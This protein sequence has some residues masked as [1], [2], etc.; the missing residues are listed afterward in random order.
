MLL[1]LRFG[2]AGEVAQPWQVEHLDKAGDRRVVAV[3]VVQPGGQAAGLVFLPGGQVQADGQHRFV[4]VHVVGVAALRLAQH[5]ACPQQLAAAGQQRRQRHAGRG[6]RVVRRVV[7][8][9]LQLELCQIGLARGYQGLGAIESRE[10][11]GGKLR[12][13]LAPG[14]RN[15]GAIDCAACKV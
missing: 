3:Q 9:V 11:N 6:R 7:A 8:P 12:H 15:S 4:G 2:V 14:G 10:F 13:G 1:G 5:H